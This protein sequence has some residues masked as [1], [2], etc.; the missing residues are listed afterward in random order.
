MTMAAEYGSSSAQV[1]TGKYNFEGIGDVP[2][3]KKEAIRWWKLA[4]ENGEDLAQSMLSSC[5]FYGDGIE[6]DV[7]EAYFW[8][9]VASEK[10]DP[11]RQE[12]RE[13]IEG[14][15]TKSQKEN[16]LARYIDWVTRKE[17]K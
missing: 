2:P 11:V 16:V 15:L 3:D 7:Q 17:H 9:L 14:N 13:M 5:Y 10:N 12:F 4:A 8:A 1:I 6:R